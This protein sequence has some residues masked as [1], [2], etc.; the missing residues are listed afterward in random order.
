[1]CP[2]WHF[3]SLFCQNILY[4]TTSTTDQCTNTTFPTVSSHYC[5]VQDT[6][7]QYFVGTYHIVLILH[8]SLFKVQNTTLFRAPFLNILFGHIKLY[9]YYISHCL[10]Y[11]ILRCSQCSGHLFSIFCLDISN[12]TNTTFFTV[13]STYY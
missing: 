5:A 12:C 2:L 4:C 9:Q 6:F 7:S 10:K 11:K 1:M 3:F 13:K 8:F